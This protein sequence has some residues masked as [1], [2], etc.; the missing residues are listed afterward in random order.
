MWSYDPATV[1]GLG[2]S[3]MYQCMQ[4]AFWHGIRTLLVVGLDHDYFEYNKM[5][6]HFDDRYVMQ[7]EDHPQ[8]NKMLNSAEYG[9]KHK[10]LTENAYKTARE[11]FEANSGQ[12]L[13]LTEGSKC[14]VFEMGDLNDWILD[15]S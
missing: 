5:P 12:I 3:V 15:N 8:V 10:L 2:G 1:I 4:V 7:P 11:I 6:E 9:A 13:N 14:D